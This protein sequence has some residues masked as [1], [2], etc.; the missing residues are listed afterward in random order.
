MKIFSEVKEKQGRG[1][2]SVNSMETSSEEAEEGKEE[3]VS[4]DKAEV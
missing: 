4:E 2:S 3:S 1:E